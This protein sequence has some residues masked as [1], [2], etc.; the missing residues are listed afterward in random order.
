MGETIAFNP[1]GVPL[2]DLPQQLSSMDLGVVGNRRSAACDL[3][4]PVK[5]LEY[6]SLGIPTVVPRLRTIEHYFSEQMVTYYEPDD[7]ESL[8]DAIF[9]M[10]VDPEARRAQAARARQ[11]LADHGWQRQGTELVTMYQQLLEN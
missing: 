10:H 1:K 6:V 5:L 7:V 8:S 3:M 9:R 2:K 11:F 4:L